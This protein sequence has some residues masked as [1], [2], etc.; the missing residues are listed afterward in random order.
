MT[1]RLVRNIEKGDIQELPG[2]SLQNC[3]A[4]LVNMAGPIDTISINRIFM[5]WFNVYQFVLAKLLSPTPPPPGKKLRRPRIAIVGAGL[6]GVAAASHCVGHGF[7]VMVFESGGKDA[8]GGIWAVSLRANT[9]R[10]EV[11]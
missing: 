6:T 3:S 2:H 5:W 9:T 11:V 8:L 7:D 1:F 10:I 4:F